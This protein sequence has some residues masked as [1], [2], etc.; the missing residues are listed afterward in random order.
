M[1]TVCKNGK[2]LNIPLPYRRTP[3]TR[4]LMWI[5]TAAAASAALAVHLDKS[6]R[7]RSKSTA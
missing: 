6:Q 4:P 5:G 2:R 1:L 3:R 7:E